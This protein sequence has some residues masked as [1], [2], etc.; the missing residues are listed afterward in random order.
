MS[1]TLAESFMPNWHNKAE[2][3]REAVQKGKFPRMAPATV[4]P[5]PMEEDVLETEQEDR[6]PESVG[7]SLSNEN[8]VCRA[9]ASLV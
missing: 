2:R 5:A 3:W 7:M 6:S 4:W 8:D 9:V 1:N